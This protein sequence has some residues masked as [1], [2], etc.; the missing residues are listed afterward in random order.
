SWDWLN[1]RRV[2]FAVSPLDVSDPTHHSAYL[3]S[4][5]HAAGT[6]VGGDRIRLYIDGHLVA[7]ELGAPASATHT[8]DLYFAAGLPSTDPNEFWQGTLDEI[9]I[10]NIARTEGEI[11]RDMHR[12]LSGSEPGL[13]GY[14]NFDEG[15]GQ[16]AHDLSPFGNDGQLGKNGE[17]GGDSGDPQWVASTAPIYGVS[18]LDRNALDGE[19]DGSFPSGDGT[20]GGDFV[21]Q[22]TIDRPPASL[23]ASDPAADGTLPKLCNNVV[24]LSFD[25]SLLLPPSGPAL[26]I[27]PVAGGADVASSFSYALEAGGSV[28]AATENGEVLVNLTWYRLMPA[29]ALDVN[30]F[31]LDLC[32][33]R[34]DADGDGQVTATDY[35]PVKNHLF[36]TAEARYDLDGDGQVLAQDYFVVKNHL[37]DAAPPKP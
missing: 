33:L 35:F 17:P 10:W 8:A 27:K 4:W 15:S 16:V 30:P 31:V 11:R 23:A 14:W 32:T 22:F 28:L 19:F 9:R 3:G 37:F 1:N 21:Y 2:N 34:G 29:P 26:S 36:E 20:P 25:R 24:R 6:F 5:H 7:E 13:V 18:D 12:T